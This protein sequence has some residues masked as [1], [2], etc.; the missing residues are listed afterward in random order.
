MY[1]P[2]ITHEDRVVYTDKVKRGQECKEGFV[3]REIEYNGKNAL[4]HYR[5]D[6]YP[7]LLEKHWRDIKLESQNVMRR[8][9][10]SACIIYLRNGQ[11]P[12]YSSDTQTRLPMRF[13][14]NFTRFFYI[15]YN[16]IRLVSSAVCQF[17]YSKSVLK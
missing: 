12:L 10:V 13:D 7:Q 8:T 15:W 9:S 1:V 17:R 14:L 3:I 11:G 2:R 16:F 4:E 5:I 6:R